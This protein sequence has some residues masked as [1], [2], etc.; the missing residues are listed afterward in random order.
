MHQIPA[1]FREPEEHSAGH[2][3]HRRRTLALHRVGAAPEPPQRGEHGP[4]PPHAE[5]WPPSTSHTSHKQRN[6]AVKNERPPPPRMNSDG[7]GA[8]VRSLATG[9][10]M[11]MGRATGSR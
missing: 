9:Q 2:R 1:G 6:R 5:P 3:S 10:S 4:E 8:V 11:Y 7:A